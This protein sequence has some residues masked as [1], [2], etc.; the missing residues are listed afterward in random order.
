MNLRRWRKRSLINSM[1]VPPNMMTDVVED[2]NLNVWDVGSSR[3]LKLDQILSMKTARERPGLKDFATSYQQI[4]GDILSGETRL[5]QV[6][7]SNEIGKWESDEISNISSSHKE[8][9][10][11][12]IESFSENFTALV[13]EITQ[14]ENFDEIICTTLR[15]TH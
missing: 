7:E 3:N 9:F 14:N 2:V 5:Q 11:K 13:E 10:E 4:M 15:S 1:V 8:I 6:Q 12:E